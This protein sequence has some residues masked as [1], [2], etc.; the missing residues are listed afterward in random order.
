MK[1]EAITVSQRKPT[2][3]VRASVSGTPR[4]ARL[5]TASSHSRSVR[6]VDAAK[7]TAYWVRNALLV[8]STAAVLLTASERPSMTQAAASAQP[9]ASESRGSS[10]SATD[11]VRP[12]P[13]SQ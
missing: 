3:S 9:R 10:E 6:K 2:A 1:A 7:T 13:P 8:K 12:E 5:A 11:G 4:T